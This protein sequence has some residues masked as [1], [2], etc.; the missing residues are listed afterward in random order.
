[1]PS[2]HCDQGH[3]YL[4]FTYVSEFFNKILKEHQLPSSPD[5][6]CAPF[7]SSSPH[8]RWFDLINGFLNLGSTDCVASRDKSRKR[9]LWNP[10]PFY[11]IKCTKWKLSCWSQQTL[12]FAIEPSECGTSPMS[13]A[14]AQW[15]TVENYFI[16][17]TASNGWLTS[18]QFEYPFNF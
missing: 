14:Q 2:R 1:M 9:D 7:L 12:I 6:T 18:M 15:K 5:Y 3:C 13:W 16:L 8:L 10:N 11:F 17:S 4:K